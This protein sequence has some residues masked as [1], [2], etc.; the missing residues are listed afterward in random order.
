MGARTVYRISVAPTVPEQTRH[1]KKGRWQRHADSS[2][3]CRLAQT[4]APAHDPPSVKSP[5]DHSPRWSAPVSLTLW[6]YCSCPSLSFLFLVFQ[7]IGHTAV[8]IN[9]CQ[10][11]SA[12]DIGSPFLLYPMRATPFVPNSSKDKIQH[13]SGKKSIYSLSKPKLWIRPSRLR[14]S[15]FTLT[16]VCRLTLI[17]KK[18]SISCRANVAIFLSIAPP[19]PMTI[20]LWLSRSQ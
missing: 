6:W 13:R 10:L 2:A 17:P 5:G 20:P 7:I 19:L 16:Q 12:I 9:C 3:A 4:H 11:F 14:Q 18:R 8:C 15:S 1:S